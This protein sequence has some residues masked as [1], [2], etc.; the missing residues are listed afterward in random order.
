MA[1]VPLD[2]YKK[3]LQL[4]SE[5]YQLSEKQI[6]NTS[7]KTKTISNARYTFYRVCS[8]VGINIRDL[9]ALF[10]MDRT[11]ISSILNHSIHKIDRVAEKVILE[12][13]NH[14]IDR[15]V[16]NS[17]C[18]PRSSFHQTQHIL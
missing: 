13:G 4:T 9:S 17:R 14:V 1:H 18:S 5:Y 11:N 12:K 16:F 8:F 2:S 7:F 6:L 3:W 15:K 10:G